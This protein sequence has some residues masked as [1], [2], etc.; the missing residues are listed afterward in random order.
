MH[1]RDYFLKALAAGCFRYKRWVIEAFSVANLEKDDAPYPYALRRDELG[2]YFLNPEA[3]GAITRVEGTT[4]DQ[5]PFRFKDSVDLKAGA[6][7]NLRKDLTST[8]GNLLFNQLVLV[9]AFG[10]KIE[11]MEGKVT[12]GRVEKI[13][14][15][16]LKDEPKAG[17]ARDPNALYVSEYKLFNDAMFALAGFTQLC[18]PSASERTMTVD[19]RIAERRA[20]LLEEYKDRLHDPV[21][22]AKIDA[23]LIAMDREWIMSDSSAGF[24]VKEKSFNIVRKKTFL[25]Q[26][27]ESGFG[28]RGELIPRSLNEG[29]DI[30]Q[31]PAMANSLRDGSFNRGS[32]TMLGG[33]ATKFNYRIFQNTSVTE[34]DCGSL[35][36]MTMALNDTNIKYFVSNSILTPQGL[37]E[38]TDENKDKFVGKSW[39]VRSPIY[40]KTG[41]PNFCAVCMGKKIASTPNALSAYAADFSSMLMLIFMGAMHGKSLK[42][43]DWDLQTALG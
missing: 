30:Q 41:A 35:R 18:V 16:R 22:Q 38:I 37:V 36:G 12:A 15:A 4:P 2:Y 34:E 10:D 21:I 42:V 24:Y 32:Q 28:V 19:P 33:E 7:P 40:C 39:Q 14:E 23:E 8:Y 13:I 11:Y 26:G 43:A 25:L 31:L 3:D 5:P 1:K 27:A 6:I 20:Q 9:Y 29:W 17:A